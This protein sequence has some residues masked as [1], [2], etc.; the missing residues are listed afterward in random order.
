MTYSITSP[1]L[2]IFMHTPLTVIF[3]QLHPHVFL[4]ITVRPLFD[5][6]LQISVLK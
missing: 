4:V 3:V 2:F 6:L 1:I 5:L